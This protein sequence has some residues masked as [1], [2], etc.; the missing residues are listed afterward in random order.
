V[1]G[2]RLLVLL[3]FATFVVAANAAGGAGDALKAFGSGQSE[4]DFLPPEKAFGVEATMRDASSAVV[5][6]RIQ[7]E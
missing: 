7:L 2:I 1:I 3:C 5:F 4:P 6:A